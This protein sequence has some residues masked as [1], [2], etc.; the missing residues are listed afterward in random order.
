[1]VE[2][3]SWDESYM[4]HAVENIHYVAFYRK[5]WP[6]LHCKVFQGMMSKVGEIYRSSVILRVRKSADVGQ[7]VFCQLCGT[8]CI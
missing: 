5:S 3:D 6:V 8:I 1:M 2:L 7:L 4:P